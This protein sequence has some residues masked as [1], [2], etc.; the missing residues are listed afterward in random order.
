MPTATPGII[1]CNWVY[2][3]VS[4][5]ST[6]LQSFGVVE[7]KRIPLHIGKPIPPAIK[8]YRVILRI[9]P[10]R[11][12]I[13]PEVVV[14]QPRLAVRILPG[15]AQVIALR[16]VA[17]CQ[18]RRSRRATSLG[19]RDTGERTACTG[20]W[21]QDAGG[22]IVSKGAVRPLPLGGVRLVGD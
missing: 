22:G 16:R 4:G 20:C 12:L 9:P 13:A 18:Q 17:H 15:K 6:I 3:W 2:A 7:R 5:S 1:C 10:L 11:C 19:Y 14:E 8:S 21:F